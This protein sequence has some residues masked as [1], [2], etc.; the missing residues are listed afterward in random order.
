MPRMRVLG[1]VL[2]TALFLGAAPPV[3]F[4]DLATPFE[5]VASVSAG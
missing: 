3:A 5:R 1:G 2:P 4:S